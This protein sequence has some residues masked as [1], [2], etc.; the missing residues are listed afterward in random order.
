MRVCSLGFGQTRS[1]VAGRT[2]IAHGTT[3]EESGFA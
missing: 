2:V 1:S 3:P